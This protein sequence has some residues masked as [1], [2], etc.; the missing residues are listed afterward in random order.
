MDTKNAALHIHLSDN[1][2]PGRYTVRISENGTVLREAEFSLRFDT[3]E[4]V[5]FIVAFE[6]GEMDFTEA[7][8]TEIGGMLYQKLFVEGD[9]D[10]LAE[11]RRKAEST[12]ESMT[13]FLTIAS[14]KLSGLPWEMMHDGRDFLSIFTNTSI[15][16]RTDKTEERIL[17]LLQPPL[18]V[19]AVISNPIDLPESN[20][21][22]IE[23]EEHCIQRAFDPLILK[24]L[25]ELDFIEEASLGEIREEL[26]RKKYNI[27][28]YSGHGTYYSD[29]DTSYLLMEDKEGK[30][31]LVSPSDLA[32]LLGDQPSMRMVFL[33]GCHTA[34]ESRA[35]GFPE[36]AARLL[37]HKV[38]SVLAMRTSVRDD[39]A[40]EFAEALYGGIAKGVPLATA[41]AGARKQ[42]LFSAG[43][44]R[45]DFAIPAL[46]SADPNPLRL[47]PTA[48][49]PELRPAPPEYL[50][51]PGLDTGFIGRRRELRQIKTE[52]IRNNRT[53]VMIHGFGGLG[54]TVLAV[55][56]A[57]KLRN[58]FPDG[59]FGYQCSINTNLPQMF[60][61]FS[62]RPVTRVRTRR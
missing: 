8:L 2:E 7:L 25:V 52:L 31:N 1:G 44:D 38:P 20:R 17:P 57:R 49:P 15:V 10:V 27:L 56:A 5:R 22:D 60:H 13:L 9:G 6:S 4:L 36:F 3:P 58:S 53:A 54:K 62:T 23:E 18:N 29:K 40:T 21:L 33:S 42:L 12:G 16:R 61:A 11:R 39:Y 51:L 47:D 43:R 30:E 50:P 55:K 34:H 41:V 46:Y 37:E 14:P 19:L 45:G 48:P 59:I 28:H 26:T 32:A 35:Q 24:G